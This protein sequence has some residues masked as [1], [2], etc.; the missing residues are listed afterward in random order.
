MHILPFYFVRQNNYCIILIWQWFKAY[1]NSS[2]IKTY[3]KNLRDENSWKHVLVERARKMLNEDISELTEN[4]VWV[5]I[6]VWF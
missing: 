2:C 1:S 6:L 4:S 5:E 3:T